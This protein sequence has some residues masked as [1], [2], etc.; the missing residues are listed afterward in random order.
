VRPAAEVVW[1]DQLIL[2]NGDRVTGS[3]IKR[4][5]SKRDEKASPF[6]SGEFAV[7]STPSE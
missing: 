5:K 1:A 7:I 3:I 4:R 6:P 2:K